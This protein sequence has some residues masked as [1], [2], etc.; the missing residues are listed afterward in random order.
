MTNGLSNVSAIASP[1]GVQNLIDQTQTVIYTKLPDFAIS[2]F[3]AIVIFFLGWIIAELARRIFGRILKMVKFEQFL[4]EQKV[5][6]ALG[7]V[8]I[9]TVLT[10]ILYYYIIV[11]F[12]QASFSILNLGTV[13]AFITQLLTFLPLLIGAVLLVVAAALIGEFIK[14]RVIEVG[15]KSPT[16][17]FLGRAAKA[18]IIFLGLVSALGTMDYRVTIIE[19]TFVALATAVFFGLALAFGLAFGLGAQGEAKEVVK[20]LRKKYKI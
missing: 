13:A 12:L 14:K 2:L 6:E 9:S 20:S 15:R 5:S 4:K 18:V 1:S 8:V 11:I 3:F 10:K 19:S 17:I 7:T 16:V